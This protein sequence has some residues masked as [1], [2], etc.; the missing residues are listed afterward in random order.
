[1]IGFHQN[2]KDMLIK[3]HHE[4]KLASHRQEKSRQYVILDKEMLSR[5]YKEIWQV[6][7]KSTNNFTFKMGKRFK[8]IN[9]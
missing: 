5:I 3:K 7:N 9:H 2:E 1:M 4:D 8:L 6:N